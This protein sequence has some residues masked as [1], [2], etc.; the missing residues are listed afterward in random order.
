ME[1]Y[2]IFVGGMGRPGEEQSDWLTA[3]VIV[4]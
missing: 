4:I 1:G 3:S 2:G